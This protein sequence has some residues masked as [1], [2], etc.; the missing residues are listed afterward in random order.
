MLAVGGAAWAQTDP[1]P[2]PVVVAMAQHHVLAN[3][4][5]AA[6]NHFDL[7]FDLAQVHPEATPDSWSVVGGFMAKHGSAGYRP[8]IYVATL[9]LVCPDHGKLDCWRLQKL[10][11]DS[12]LVVKEGRPV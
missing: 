9:R 8:H 11:I 10:T 3:F 12:V 1:P 4:S 5:R 7:A 2:T 6:E